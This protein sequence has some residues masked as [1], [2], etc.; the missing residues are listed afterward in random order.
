MNRIGSR[1]KVADSRPYRAQANRPTSPNFS[2][3]GTHQKTSHDGDP[4]GCRHLAERMRSARMR[5]RRGAAASGRGASS[6][7]PALL[8]SFSAGIRFPAITRGAP[9]SAFPR[10]RGAS[11]R[12]RLVTQFCTQPTLDGSRSRRRNESARRRRIGDCHC[13]RRCAADSRERTP[14]YAHAAARRGDHARAR[15]GRGRTAGGGTE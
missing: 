13:F 8:Q 10:G 12:A 4:P 2:Q 11:V 3:N 5:I 15:A 1:E 6:A 7:M 9:I 14:A